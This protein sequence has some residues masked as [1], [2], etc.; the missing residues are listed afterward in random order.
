MANIKSAKKRIEVSR[1]QRERNKSRRTEIK[2]YIKKFDAAVEENKADEASELIKLIDKKMKKSALHGV[3]HKNA[4]SRKLSKL[5]LKL[6]AM[7]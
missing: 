6:N 2:T 3:I 1:L 5:Q 7:A 4:A